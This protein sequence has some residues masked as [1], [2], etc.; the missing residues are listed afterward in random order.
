M[1]KILLAIDA[2]KPDIKSLDF[3]CYI[4]NLTKS[5]VTGVFLENLVSTE[6]REKIFIPI[7]L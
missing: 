7:T 6:N 1:E 4:A 5:K 3:A 2:M